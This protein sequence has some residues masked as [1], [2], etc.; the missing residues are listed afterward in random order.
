MQRHSDAD[1]FDA[2]PPMLHDSKLIKED[3]LVA[4]SIAYYKGNRARD[5]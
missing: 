5:A 2:L 1:L 3:A 4:V